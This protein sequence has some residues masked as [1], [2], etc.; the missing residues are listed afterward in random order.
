M[1]DYEIV[2]FILNDISDDISDEELINLLV[3]KTV[4][5]DFKEKPSF[6]QRAADALASFAGSWTFI[7][8]FTVVLILWIAF[9]AVFASKAFDPYPYILLNLVLS[10]IASIQAPLIMM[11]Q[12][13]QDDRD[14]R[15]SENDYKVNLKCEI[16]LKNIHH[17]LDYISEY[18]YDKQ[19]KEQNSG[20][21]T[22]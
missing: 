7:I 3:D 8:S 15:R 21:E 18:I 14:R 22:K 10:C 2:K 4:S 19:K 20:M 9:N 13:R 17:K 5:S 12:K 11:S 6:G 16:L 1:N